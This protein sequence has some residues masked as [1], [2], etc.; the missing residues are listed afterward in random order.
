LAALVTIPTVLFLYE[1]FVIYPN[2]SAK[3]FDYG[4]KQVADFLSANNLW[5]K[6]ILINKDPDRNLTLSFYN[7]YQPPLNR[8]TNVFTPLEI[9]KDITPFIQG[10]IDYE[11]RIDKGYPGSTSSH[12]DLFTTN[13]TSRLSLAIYHNTS[14][15]APNNYLLLQRDYNNIGKS[16]FDQRPLNQTI[17]YDKWYKVRLKI[18]ST[19]ISFYFDGRPITTLSR[20]SGND[21]MYTSIHLIGESAAVSF[22]NMVIEQ[23]HEFSDLVG[24]TKVKQD[25]DGQSIVSLFLASNKTSNSAT[26]LIVVTH[27]QER[28][29]LYTKYGKSAQLLK[30]IYSP[31][32]T[33]ALDIFEI[34]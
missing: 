12:I 18:N 28:S 22:K 30:E 10:T 24:I 16:T 34:I 25:T 19:A 23:N 32:G 27:P 13:Q 15:F 33:V 7:P 5:R 2:Q 21:N 31:D 26:P 17:E 29:L 1:Y 11:T 6:D 3:V 20:P 14:S 4:Y 9:T 8:I